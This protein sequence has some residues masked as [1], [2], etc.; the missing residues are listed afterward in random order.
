MCNYFDLHLTESCVL[1]ISKKLK[2][3]NIH[4]QELFAAGTDTTSSTLE[5]AMAEVLK[6]SETVLAKAKAELSQVIGKGK[7]VEEADIS[8]LKYLSCIVKETARLHPPVPFLLPRQ[9]VEDVELCGYTFQRIHKCLSM[10]MLSDASLCYGKI[11]CHFNLRGSWI[12]KLTCMAMIL[13]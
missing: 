8:K 4:G 3:T 12:R 10:H 5:W 9:V 13:S 11:H 1:V 6:H 7:T 2:I